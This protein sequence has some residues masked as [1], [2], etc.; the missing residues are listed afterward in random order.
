MVILRPTA[1]LRKA[2][3]VAKG[4]GEPSDT[5]LGDWYANRIVV[6]RQ[7]LILLVSSAC[8]LAIVVPARDVKTLPRRLVDL[9]EARLRRLDLAQGVIDAE[10]RAMTPTL[11]YATDDRSV[12][13]S[14]VD[15]AKCAKSR[16]APVP[17]NL[18]A[19]HAVEDLLGGMPCHNARS[20]DV[21][22]W[23][24]KR[25]AELLSARWL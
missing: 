20:G 25:A 23:P 4:S 15:F 12:L 21:V 5:A 11:V 9:V 2:I 16:R 10:C 14:M 13:G 7:P 3:P 22:I 17:W 6:D 19:S 24:E 8:L 1:K 18:A